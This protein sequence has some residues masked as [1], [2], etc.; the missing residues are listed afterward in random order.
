[1]EYFRLP[2][3]AVLGV[4]LYDEPLNATVFVGAA[5]I[6]GGNLVNLRA[7]TRRAPA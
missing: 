1:M 5:L 2:V 6:I 7:E 3:M 4:V